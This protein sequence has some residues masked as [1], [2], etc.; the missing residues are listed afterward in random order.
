MNYS[1]SGIQFTDYW[2]YENRRWLFDLLRSNPDAVKLYRLPF[3]QYEK[4]VGCAPGR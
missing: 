4:A 2:R 3:A 1:I